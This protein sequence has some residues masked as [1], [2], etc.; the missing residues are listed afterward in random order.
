MKGILKTVIAASCVGLL[1]FAQT[2]QAQGRRH[3]VDKEQQVKITSISN[4]GGFV[5]NRIELNR[6]VYLKNF[7]I[8]RYV[9]FI[10]KRQHTAWDWTKAEQHG[11]WLESSLLS[12]L[13]GHD[14]ALLDKMK[15]ELHEII[16]SQEPDGYLG[17]TAK[18][19]RSADRPTRGMDAYEL[20]FVFHALI[21]IYEQSGDEAALRSVKALADYYL[22]NFGDGKKEFWPSDMRAPENWHKQINGLS[23]FAGHGVHYSLEGTLLCDPITRLYEVTGEKKYLD[24]SRWVV[25]NID[26][27]SGWDTFSRLDSVADGT[28]TVDKLQPYVH[29]H[30]LHMNLM[31]FLRLYKCTGDASLL[32]K[33]VGAWKDIEKRQMYITGGVSVAEHYEHDYVKPMSGNIVETCATMSWMQLTQMLLEITGDPTYADYIERIAIN[34]VFAAQDAKLGTCRYHTAP[35]GMTPDGYFHGPDCCTASGHRII[36]LMPTFFYAQNGSKFYINQY[37]PASYSDKRIAF[38]VDGDYPYTES[39]SIRITA[40]SKGKEEINL[41][42]PKWCDAPSVRLNGK[43]VAGVKSG[44][45]AKIS[46]QWK[47]GDVIELSFP[48]QLRWVRREN[49]SEYNIWHQPSGEIMYNSSPAKR[50]PYALLRGPVVYALDMVWNAGVC[51]D[52]VDIARDVRY[53]TSKTPVQVPETEADR[54]QYISPLYKAEGFYDNRPVTFTLVPFASIGKWWRDGATEPAHHANAFSYAIWVY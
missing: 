28:L 15:K 26:K 47:K 39:F 25:K 23:E 54:K 46:R 21:T 11:K 45:Y 38:E 18:S 1:A 17:A 22:N 33:V 35:N 43:A 52:N 13:Q 4:I 34:H 19:F 8:E 30:T 12:G 44:E 7:P 31:G 27:W 2:A 14:Q 53:D 24:W 10:V 48:M 41:R 49:H 40:N 51:P 29:A 50:V 9:D 3:F 32:R 37:F 6:D 16:A 5:G 42:M 20:Y 36:S